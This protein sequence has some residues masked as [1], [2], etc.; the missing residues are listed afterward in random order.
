MQAEPDEPLLRVAGQAAGNPFLLVE[1]L[2]GLRQEGLVRV[3]GRACDANRRQ[4]SRPSQHEHARASGPHVRFQRVESPR[5]PGRSDGRFPSPIWGRCSGFARQRCL[6]SVEELMEA[7]IVTERGEQ[8]SLPARP[9][10]R[11]SAPSLPTVGPPCPRPTG[12]R[13]D[14]GQ[15]GTAG[16]SGDPACRQRRAGGR[17]RHHDSPGGGRGAGDH[18][19]GSQRRPQPTGAGTGPA[20]G[21]LYV[22]R[23]SCKRRCRSTRRVGSTRRRRSRTNR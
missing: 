12:R 19:S 3:D 17:G 15:G 9:D 2:E 7:G 23:S 14:A 6:T 1:L 5:W 18:R 20:T 16:R 8:L 10:S 22:R 4:A 21:I 11:S 13:R